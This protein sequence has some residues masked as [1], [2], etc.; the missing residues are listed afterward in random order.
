[1]AGLA[2]VTLVG[3]LVTDPE[4]S[5]TPTGVAVA[6]FTV[7]ANDGRYDP[8]TGR[9]ADKGT[10]FLRC[11]IYRHAAENVAESLTQGTR[12][13]VTGVLRQR[14]WDTVYGDKRY[15]YELDATE[16]GASLKSATVEVTKNTRDTTI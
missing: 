16:V 7:A 14:D 1:M 6:T 12:V 11:S 15:A 10:T 5:T 8:E 9:W 2:E 4:L 13:L 3:I